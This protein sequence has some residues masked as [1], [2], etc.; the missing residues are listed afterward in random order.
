MN[1]ITCKELI[2]FLDDY[3]AGRLGPDQRREFDRHLA[4]CAECIQYLESYR[5]A[6]A[7]G[8]AAE[9]IA[10]E[11]APE[12]LVQAILRARPRP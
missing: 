10:P 2:D 6:V 4:L 3:V 7:A 1:L 11:S 5:R 12:S 9:S 8:R